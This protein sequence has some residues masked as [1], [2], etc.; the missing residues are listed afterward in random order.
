[1]SITGGDVALSKPAFKLLF[2]KLKWVACILTFF[3]VASAAFTWPLVLHLSDSLPDWGDPADNAWRIG[4]IAHQLL[5]NPFNLY[6]TNAFYPLK[7][8]LALNELV[9][10]EGLLGAPI[11]WLTGNPPLAFNLL[12][13]SSYV[14][15]GVAMWLL[16]RYLTRSN[17]AGLIAGM[18]YAFSPF[19]FG[20]YAH[21]GLGAQQ[22]MVFALYFLIRFLRLS[23]QEKLLEKQQPGIV[24]RQNV[25]NLVLFGG[26]FLIQALVAGYYAYFE[27]ILTG[28]FLLYYL[29]FQTGLPS[30]LW[31]SVRFKKFSSLEWKLPFK[32]MS[33][34]VVVLACAFLLLLPF[35]RPFVE[36]KDFFGFKRNLS[37]VNYWSAA[38]NSLLRTLP[39]SWLY[40]PVQVGFFHL[41]TSAERML[42]PGLIAVLLA[43]AGLTLYR[44]K[45]RPN[46][47]SAYR[48]FF[49]F[50]SLTG[51][52]LSFGP[53]L[54]LEAYGLNPTGIPMP[55]KWL[56]Q[57]IPG[58]DALRVAQRFG[59]LLM[60]GLAVCAGFG[61]VWLLQK[62]QHF[63]L[64]AGR[65]PEGVSLRVIGLAF[66]LIALVTVDYFA[67]GMPVMYT[68]TGVNAPPLYQWLSAESSKEVIAPD[69]LLLELPISEPT[70]VTNSPIYL[71]YSLSHRRPM[72]N[73]SAN[74]IPAGYERLYYE[75]QYFPGPSS[76]H[77]IE[78][79]GVAFVIVHTGNLTGAARE[80]LAQ[81]TGQ[82]GRLE[83]IKAF[84]D[85][86]GRPGFQ[87]I[88]YKVKRSNPA[89]QKLQKVIPGGAEVLLV[90]PPSNRRLAVTCISGLLGQ[91]RRFFA[92]YHTI[93]DQILGG[94]QE[95]KSNYRYQYAIFYAKS[96]VKPAQYGYKP[97][98][99]IYAD[100][101]LNIEVFSSQKA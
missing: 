58:F 62:A 90:D 91:D 42:Y 22:W 24:S 80:A 59:Q 54:N 3:V 19:H 88:V 1:M 98:D 20:Q 40:K 86:E 77:V 72:L 32:Q 78:S 13:Y 17:M 37:E 14:L 45:M 41:Q 49:A 48:W 2:Y 84:A 61:V 27:A 55:Y 29:L 79:L 71:M 76:L 34:V 47:F 63:N 38:P 85:T 95:A 10:G 74:I 97:E 16:V 5:Q 66:V 23:A 33:L 56:Y 93:Y 64:K 8:G 26:F 52:L 100:K 30:T 75:M 18:I 65:F 7:S 25:I 12:N 28:L 87:D 82:S 15:S 46:P 68:G 81:Y 99:M 53:T 44:D 11:V 89:L 36:A 57:L 43:L 4:S 73:G 9:T 83:L 96:T 67:P 51:L 6:G 69:A 92:P 70:P 60:L 35:I 94:I 101:D 31:H 50:I 21:L 39:T